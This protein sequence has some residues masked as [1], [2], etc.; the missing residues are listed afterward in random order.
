MH[1]Q[2]TV[3]VY[4]GTVMYYDSVFAMRMRIDIRH[5]TAARTALAQGSMLGNHCF[6]LDRL[7]SSTVQGQ[8]ASLALVYSRFDQP[9]DVV[10]LAEWACVVGGA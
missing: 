5:D 7:L 8:R 1:N 2:H 10:R 6:F 9:E 4:T 3:H